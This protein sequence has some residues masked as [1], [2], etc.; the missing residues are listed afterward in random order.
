[1]TTFIA[2]DLYYNRLGTK[3]PKRVQTYATT[4]SAGQ[5]K[6]SQKNECNE[7]RIQ[8]DW[9]KKEKKE[10]K[11][12]ASTKSLLREPVWPSGKALGW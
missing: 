12:S 8:S 3:S 7:V 4:A 2:L 1:M 6:R 5:P 10:K 9:L 11:K